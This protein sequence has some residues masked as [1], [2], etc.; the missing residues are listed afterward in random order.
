MTQ[1]TI[2]ICDTAKN[3]TVIN[4]V[5]NTTLVEHLLLNTLYLYIM[6][7]EALPSTPCDLC[8]EKVWICY[9]RRC[10]YK[11]IHYLTLTPRSRGRGS[12]SHKMLASTLDIMWPTCMHQQSLMLLRPMVKE[13]MHL[14]ENTLFDLGAQDT[15]NVAQYPL[16]HVTW[17]INWRRLLTL[18]IFQRSLLKQFPIIKRLAITLMDCNRLH[19]WW[20]TQ[21]RLATL[22]SSLMHTGGSDFRLYNV[23]RFQLEDLSIDEMVGAWCFG[24]LSGPPGFTCWISF[25]PVF[26]FIDCWV[27]IFALSP[28][29]ILI[30]MFWEMMHW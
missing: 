5:E 25:A 27:L 14:Q 6:W 10:I 2:L 28:C 29:Y 17:C 22:L 26:S 9:G 1:E 3:C 11:K 20:S 30:Y 7:H 4:G 21:S 23:R 15:Q 8:N 18:I 19:A 13:K 12:R 24:C 16:H